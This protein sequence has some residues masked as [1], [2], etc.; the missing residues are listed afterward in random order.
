MYNVLKLKLQEIDFRIDYFWQFMENYSIV[1]S[2]GSHA[3]IYNKEKFK[4][5]GIKS[6]NTNIY[7][8]IYKNYFW[9][10]IGS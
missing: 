1:I 6:D 2:F 5:N 7:K 3:I 10:Q 8:Y 9:I 4:V